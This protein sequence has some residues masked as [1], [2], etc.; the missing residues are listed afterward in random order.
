[1]QF[2]RGHCT[3]VTWPSALYPR[4]GL[5]VPTQLGFFIKNVSQ[6]FEDTSSDAAKCKTMTAFSIKI[7]FCCVVSAVTPSDAQLSYKMAPE[8]PLRRSNPTFQ[9][10]VWNLTDKN[11]CIDTR[12][13]CTE[14]WSMGVLPADPLGALQPRG[15][16]QGVWMLLSAP[17]LVWGRGGLSQTSLPTSSL[18]AGCKLNESDP[19]I[20]LV[21]GKWGR[22]NFT[23]KYPE[24]K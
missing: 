14:S 22:E 8:W 3:Q 18:C 4:G 7:L 5:V 1:M 10:T 21:L 17:T 13:F 20:S 24:L 19:D 16:P 15:D 6:D 11:P 9:N 2:T 23:T 12:G